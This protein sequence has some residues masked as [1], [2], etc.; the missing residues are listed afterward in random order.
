MKIGIVNSDGSIFSF[1]R[2]DDGPIA[3]DKVIHFGIKT[4]S[5][6]SNASLKGTYF[7][8][9]YWIVSTD[10]NI[11]SFIGSTDDGLFEK[12]LVIHLGVKNSNNV[13]GDINGDGIIN[14]TDALL[15][16]NK[17]KAE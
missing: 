10:G 6:M 3:D 15:L 11:F 4:S 5:N 9:D 2:S 1:I 16:M 17:L 7:S 14:I 13:T 8:Y 12:D